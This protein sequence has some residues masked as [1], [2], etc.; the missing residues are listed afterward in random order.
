METDLIVQPGGQELLVS[1]VPPSHELEPVGIFIDGE[2]FSPALAEWIMWVS[3]R[4]GRAT[5]RYLYGG[6][7][8]FRA[9]KPAMETHGFEARLHNGGK[10]A[11]DHL[12]IMDAYK[13]ALE[14]SH[15]H[16]LFATRDGDLAGTVLA[17]RVLGC[18]VCGVGPTMA[19]TQLMANCDEF[20]I[21]KANK[22]TIELTLTINPP[23]DVL[24]TLLHLRC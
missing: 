9:W 8:T 2:N 19:S 4:Y 7:H 11:A 1:Y 24:E 14:G 23:L 3:H 10:N 18:K 16:F 6:E 13:L 12:M 21:I 15:R 5:V 20:T 22:T 17:L